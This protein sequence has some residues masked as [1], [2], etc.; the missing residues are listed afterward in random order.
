MRSLIAVNLEGCSSLDQSSLEYLEF[1]SELRYLNLIG[2]HLEQSILAILETKL[3]NL[4]DLRLSKL[5]FQHGSP[6]SMLKSHTLDVFVAQRSDL[7]WNCGRDFTFFALDVSQCRLYGSNNFM[8]HSRILY[9]DL[10]FCKFAS[11][12]PDISSHYFPKSLRFLGLKG[13][14]EFKPST[15]RQILSC[16]SSLE[17]LDL[18]LYNH[19]GD[20]L[21]RPDLITGSNLKH[22]I[23]HECSGF[24]QSDLL[25]C[26]GAVFPALEKLDVSGCLSIDNDNLL[27]MTSTLCRLKALNVGSLL[28]LNTKVVPS[29]IIQNKSLSEIF[30]GGCDYIDLSQ[31]V[32]F[33]QR[34]AYVKI[35]RQNVIADAGSV[36]LIDELFQSPSRR[37]GS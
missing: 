15:I 34:Y 26:F 20:I 27:A 33:M 3:I 22:L 8:M 17:I 10:S 9:L 1:L 7:G 32:Q 12:L 36:S 35:N 28:K 24:P 14:T 11:H 19:I 37:Y 25:C 30:I 5:R 23:L 13:C 21:F 16:C 18:S 4:K 2:V 6:S 29:L 31:L